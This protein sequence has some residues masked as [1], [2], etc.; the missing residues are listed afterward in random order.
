LGFEDFVEEDG[1]DGQ[2][3]EEVGAAEAGEDFHA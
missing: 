3:E 2:G 1:G